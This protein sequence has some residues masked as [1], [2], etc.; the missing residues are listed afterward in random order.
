MKTLTWLLVISQRMHSG[1]GRYF[2][3]CN[4]LT[5]CGDGLLESCPDPDTNVENCPLLNVR[6]GTFSKLSFHI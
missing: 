5:F 3:V 6:E 1:Q 4:A 2:V